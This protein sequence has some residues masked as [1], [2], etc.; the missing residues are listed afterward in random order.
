MLRKLGMMLIAL[1]LPLVASAESSTGFKEGVHYAVLPFPVKTADANRVEVV[2]AFGY[3]CPH[4][5]S[6]EPMVQNWESKKAEDVNFV[7]LPVVFG[8]SWEPFARAYYSSEL[9]KTV[10]KTHVPTFNAVHVERR[11]FGNK[12]QLVEFYGKLGVDEAKFSKMF[13][14]FAVTM[15]LRQGDSK[16]RGYGITGVPSMVVNGKYRVTAQMAGSHQ[17]ML[18]VVDYLVGKERKPAQ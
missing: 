10:E 15:K 16:L 1:M 12:G 18:D 7:R 3:P 14:S 13:D 8:R 11:R 2:E 17:K 5:N 6:F 9:L 4:C